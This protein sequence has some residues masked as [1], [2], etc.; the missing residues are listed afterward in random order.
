[1]GNLWG[2]SRKSFQ[3]SC[4]ILGE[5]LGT[6]GKSLGAVWEILSEFLWNPGGNVVISLIRYKGVTDDTFLGWAHSQPKRKELLLG[7]PRPGLD[8]G[9]GGWIGFCL[10]RP[11]H[12]GSFF[13]NLDP[14]PGDMEG[15]L[16]WRSRTWPGPGFRGL[17]PRSIDPSDFVG[18][19]SSN[20]I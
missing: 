15:I 11:G 18:G 20:Y 12:Q 9:R 19:G 3:N 13:F 4:G 17:V 5:S 16:T 2:Q 14:F 10:C 1:M 7:H 6:F 8:L